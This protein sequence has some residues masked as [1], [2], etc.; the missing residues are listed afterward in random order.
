MS[1]E[2]KLKKSFSK[3]GVRSGSKKGSRGGG[4]LRRGVEG[5]FGDGVMTPVVPRILAIHSAVIVGEGS[6]GVV[7]RGKGGKE[8][9]RSGWQ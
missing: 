5:W 3:M 2:A 9:A 1:V 8:M 6:E 4:H 7:R